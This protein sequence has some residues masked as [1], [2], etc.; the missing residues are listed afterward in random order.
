[1]TTDTDRRIANVS[2][3]HCFSSQHFN[4]F[5]NKFFHLL[6]EPM[7][8]LETIKIGL[9]CWHKACNLEGLGKSITLIPVLN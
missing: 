8:V 7:A 6:Q 9:K 2:V 3:N 5:Y 1:M 4:D